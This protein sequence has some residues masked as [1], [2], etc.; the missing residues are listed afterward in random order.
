MDENQHERHMTR[1]QRQAYLV[2]FLQETS[3]GKKLLGPIPMLKRA[4]I[5]IYFGVRDHLPLL[6]SPR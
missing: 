4:I 5:S 3:N 6:F 2:V 1:V